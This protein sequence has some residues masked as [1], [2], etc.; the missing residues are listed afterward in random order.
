MIEKL[1]AVIV[2]AM[3]GLLVAGFVV[4]GVI[5]VAHAVGGFG[6][7]TGSVTNVQ[8][9]GLATVTLATAVDST[10]AVTAVTS[11]YVDVARCVAVF[12]AVDNANDTD[13]EGT[14]DGTVWHL[15]D[16]A[17]PNTPN[18]SFLLD[19]TSGPWSSMRANVIALG[20]GVDVTVTCLA[21]MRR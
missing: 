6:Q 11:D 18:A 12:S 16:T 15:I 21:T 10:G 4:F 8:V 13:I 2:G 7:S 14:V 17:D 5:P 9:T 19:D 20:A 3:C 1:K